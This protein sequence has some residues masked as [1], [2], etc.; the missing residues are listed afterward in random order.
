MS[1][2]SLPLLHKIEAQRGPEKADPE[3]TL[4]VTGFCQEV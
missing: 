2:S 3:K 4:S 1:V